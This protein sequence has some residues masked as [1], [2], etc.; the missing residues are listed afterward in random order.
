MLRKAAGLRLQRAA[1]ARAHAEGCLPP[2]EERIF[3]GL[4]T[5]AALPWQQSQALSRRPA[6]AIPGRP[7]SMLGVNS[8]QRAWLMLC[9]PSLLLR[10]T[11]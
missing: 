8:M 9:M 2:D 10:C 4:W 1:G 3:K 5:T 11:R 7:S 6:S